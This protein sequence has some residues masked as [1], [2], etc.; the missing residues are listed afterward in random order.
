MT[1]STSTVYTL[2]APTLLG[3]WVH[4]VSDPGGT[5]H[6]YLY[7]DQL[8]VET[9]NPE[10]VAL[11]FVGRVYPVMEYGQAEAH[12]VRRSV[13]VPFSSTHDSE[14]QWIR[15]AVRART[16][17]CYRDGRSRLIF[18]ALDRGTTVTDVKDGSTI[19][20]DLTRVDYTEGV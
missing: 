15:D 12:S 14:V 16:T 6:H 19:D 3:S 17:L 10:S 2:A 20:L 1:T 8:A 18:A 11:G 9:I 7:N 13:K 4:R 5:I